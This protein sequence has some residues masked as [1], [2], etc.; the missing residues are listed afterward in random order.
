MFYFLLRKLTSRGLSNTD[1]YYSRVEVTQYCT[2]NPGTV[3]LLFANLSLGHLLRFPSWLLYVQSSC[4]HVYWPCYAENCWK[5][6]I[7]IHTTLSFPREENISCLFSLI[8]QKWATGNIQI[9]ILRGKCI[10]IA[11]IGLM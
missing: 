7:F 9:I 10:I 4:L 2:E 6:K 3:S 1:V 11:K 8:G 5:N